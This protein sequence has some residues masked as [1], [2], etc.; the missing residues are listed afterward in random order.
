MIRI[1]VGDGDALEMVS[2]FLLRDIF[3]DLSSKLSEMA[4][5]EVSRC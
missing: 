5:V 4:L 1:R 3:C 2:L